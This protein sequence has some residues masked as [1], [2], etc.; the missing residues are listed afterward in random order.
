LRLW[1]VV[2]VTSVIEDG[3]T[4]ASTDYLCDYEKGQLWRRAGT[5]DYP[6]Y[7]GRD[8]VQV[9]YRSGRFSATSTVSERYKQ[10]A[11]LMLTHLW[12]SRQWNTSGITSTDFAVPQVAF[13][14]YS[15]PNAVVEWFGLEWRDARR[16]G[17]A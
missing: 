4:L 6:W 5:W 17:F 8:N 11:Y 15:V 2:A 9:G 13:P 16:G 10:G 12:R 7:V 1:P 14:A 3:T